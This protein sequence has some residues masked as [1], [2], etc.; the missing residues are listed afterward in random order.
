MRHFAT[1]ELDTSLGVYGA[2]NRT[3]MRV[4]IGL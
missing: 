2:Q 1:K 4:N 3:V